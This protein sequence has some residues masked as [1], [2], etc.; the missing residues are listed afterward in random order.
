M[1]IQ[2]TDADYLEFVFLTSRIHFL[3]SKYMFYFLESYYHFPKCLVDFQNVF[4]V[5]KY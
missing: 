5:S 3:N 2:S 1:N 4:L